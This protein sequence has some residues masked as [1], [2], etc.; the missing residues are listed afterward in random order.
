MASVSSFMYDAT[1]I[2]QCIKYSCN[3][4]S[5]YITKSEFKNSKSEL[6][7]VFPTE[8]CRDPIRKIYQHTNLHFLGSFHFMTLWQVN[9]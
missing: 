2:L 1:F 9:Y 5:K 3:S 6:K 7:V 4:I 8:I